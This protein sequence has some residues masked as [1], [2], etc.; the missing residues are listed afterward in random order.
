[1]GDVVPELIL[2]QICY[3][4]LLWNVYVFSLSTKQEYYSITSTG[5]CFYITKF[6]SSLPQSQHALTPLGFSPE[7]PGDCTGHRPALRGALLV[8]ALL[9]GNG[10]VAPTV[11]L[12]QV[13][14]WRS[15]LQVHPPPYIKG[16]GPSTFTRHVSACGSLGRLCMWVAT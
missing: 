6:N 1:M 14:S 2:K 4:I 3:I 16:I 13:E 12:K 15:F 10:S 7:G 8:L 11:C 9:F 5:T